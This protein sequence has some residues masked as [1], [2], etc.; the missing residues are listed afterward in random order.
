MPVDVTVIGLGYVGLPLVQEATRAGL[1][2][3][4][5]D[6]S[7]RVVAGLNGG[8]SHI[9]DIDDD[10]LREILDAGFEAS[11]SEDVIR[12]ADTVVICVQTPLGEDGGPDLGAVF[13]RAGLG[14]GGLVQPDRGLLRHHHR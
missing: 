11:T 7:D 14:P 5:F 1:T 12:D 9:D 4:G 6:I 8:T 13:P 3:R 2:V 10:E